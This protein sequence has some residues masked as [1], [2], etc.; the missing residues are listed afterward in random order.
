MEKSLMGRPEGHFLLLSGRVSI[1]AKGKGIRM[2][3][4]GVDIGRVVLRKRP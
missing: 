3:L 4:G 2:G 1:G